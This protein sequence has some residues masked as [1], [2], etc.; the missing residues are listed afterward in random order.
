MSP[1]NGKIYE[2]GEFRLQP[3]ENI[4]EKNGE[5]ITLKPKAFLTLVFLVESAGKLVEKSELLDKV[6]E[7][8][9]VEEASVSKCIW[10]IR[11][12]LDDDSKS[13]K[14]IQTVPKR[15]YRFVADVK[16][17]GTSRELTGIS[18][19]PAGVSGSRADSN[20]YPLTRSGGTL[21]ELKVEVLPDTAVEI[22]PESPKVETTEKPQLSMV[23]NRRS[24]SIPV[25]YIAALLAIAIVAVGLTYYFYPTN[26]AQTAGSDDVS[27]L[28]ILPLKPVVAGTR[29]E[30]VEFAIA[31]ALIVKA[32]EA[33]NLNVKRLFAVRKFTDLSTDPVEAGREL[34]VK[35]VLSSTYQI[36]DDRIR[37]MAQLINVRT[38]ET[39]QTFRSEAEMGNIF[40]IQDTVSKDICSGL[41]SSFGGPT[42]NIAFKRG[43]DN[44]K[45]YE[46]YQE[47]LYL[48]DKFTR[49]DSEKAIRILDMATALDP[50]FAAAHA[51]KAQAYCQFAHLGGGPPSN[52]FSIAR[53]SLDKALA[54]DSNN[55]VALTVRGMLSR[56]FYWNLPDAYRDL[57]KAIEIDP[58]ST[59]T[60]RVLAGVYYRDGRFSEAVE[61]QQRAV[62]LNPTDLWDKWFLADYQIAAGSTDDG[63]R[64]LLRITDM[65]AT[66]QPAY[67]SL[68]RTYLV[69]GDTAKAYEYLIKS[70]QSWNDS[71]DE[72]AKFEKIY[73]TS[74]WNGVM[75]AEL[76]L[77][78]SQDKPGQY[79]TK[80]V[81][82]AELAAQL[83]ENDIAFNYLDEALE[84][85]LLAFSYI[86]VDP[87]FDPIRNDPR[88]SKLLAQAKL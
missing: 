83:G 53:P 71:A 13:S 78:R 21:P 8:A 11:N 24:R 47:G 51:M 76:A 14:F 12:A 17:I 46:L 81:Y 88:Y 44:K 68:W 59:I 86:R 56:D 82:I 23:T 52:L 38:G 41:Y 29:D 27:T 69:K 32:A 79:S 84:F 1:T 62:D 63:I 67:Y 80:K 36:A 4:L 43:T 16:S 3:D 54:I 34:D 64:N 22:I 77:M 65:D 48:V 58:N 2:F 55:A 25:K 40:A 10:E 19:P 6:W 42:T 37:V 66:F 7:N 20:I 72:I 15:G 74:G 57:N 60:R 28:A 85:R 70:K 50:N 5:P 35:Y 61:E 30:S 39:E 18:T 31:E 75:N 73:A 87:L 33:K 45:A 49:E 9:F 26:T